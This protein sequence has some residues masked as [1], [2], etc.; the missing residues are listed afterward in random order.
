M[1]KILLAEDNPLNLEITS[2]MLLSLGFDVI[3][4]RN[5]REAFKYY[6]SHFREVDLI[7]L[8]MIMPEMGAYE[9]ALALKDVNPRAKLLLCSGHIDQSKINQTMNAGFEAFIPKPFNLR[10][11][12]GAINHSL[13]TK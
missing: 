4:C 6:R 1:Q 9:C 10:D 7:F 12:S 11:L 13:G 3:A 2:K 5:G 8:D